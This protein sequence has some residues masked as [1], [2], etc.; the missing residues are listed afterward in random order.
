[1]RIFRHTV[2][3][4]G[5]LLPA[6]P[7]FLQFDHASGIVRCVTQHFL[8]VSYYV[9][10]VGHAM[11]RFHEINDDNLNEKISIYE[12]NRNLIT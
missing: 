12:N 6:M 7:H 8:Q 11:E 1:M 5:L 2:H 4:I 10:N 3:D 9:K